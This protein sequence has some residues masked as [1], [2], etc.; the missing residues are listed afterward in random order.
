[1]GG[2]GVVIIATTV[3][4]NILWTFVLDTPIKERVI[5]RVTG[6]EYSGRG[7]CNNFSDEREDKKLAD[8]GHTEGKRDRENENRIP[9]R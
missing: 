7:N 5:S 1:M 4:G 8:N 9:P 3:G 6:S 2:A